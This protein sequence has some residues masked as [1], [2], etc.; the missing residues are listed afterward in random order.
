[1]T[2]KSPGVDRGFSHEDVQNLVADTNP[3]P[4]LVSISIIDRT[5]LQPALTGS[6]RIGAS[7]RE[8][9][10]QAGTDREADPTPMVMMTAMVPTVRPR[11]RARRCC[12]RSN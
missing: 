9:A 10:E 3:A 5:S 11:I 6:I 7:D 4:T 8:T 1:V 2:T 12:R